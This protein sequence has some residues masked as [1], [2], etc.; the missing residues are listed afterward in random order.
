MAKNQYKVKH[1]YAIKKLSIRRVMKIVCPLFLTLFT[2]SLVYSQNGKVLGT[3][4]DDQEAP[5]LG[6]IFK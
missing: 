5:L 4:T 3:I 1:T 2:S 6:A